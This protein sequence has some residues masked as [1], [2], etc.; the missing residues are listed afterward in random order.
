[1]H[2]LVMQSIAEQRLEDLRKDS[3]PFTVGRLRRGPGRARTNSSHGPLGR[4]ETRIG[5]WM[6]TTG[7]RLVHNGSGSGGRGQL[8]PLSSSHARVSS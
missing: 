1:M 2:P 5:T 6:V 4:T 7:L 3:R 8:R